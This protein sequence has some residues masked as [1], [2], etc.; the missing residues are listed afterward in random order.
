M[1]GE[2]PATCDRR[3]ERAARARPEASLLPAALGHRY[4][5][6]GF[7]GIIVAIVILSL[8]RKLKPVRRVIHSLLL[9][10][11]L[12]G[13]FTKQVNLA[14]FTRVM[15]TLLKSGVPMSEALEI[16]RPTISNVFYRDIVDAA[17]EEIAKGNQLSD[18]FKK[19]PR[20][21]PSIAQRLIGVGEESGTLDE[22]LLY[23]ADFYELEVQSLTKNMAQLFEPVLVILIGLVVFV[24]AIAIVS[25]MYQ[26]LGSI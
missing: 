17:Q 20:R 9:H 7:Y 11:P 13:R 5:H 22:M 26:I 24:L 8:I 15:G 2:R 18:A 1:N 6:H 21:M 19:Y 23:L 12:A 16:S 10:L 4:R 25:P 14:S 3:P